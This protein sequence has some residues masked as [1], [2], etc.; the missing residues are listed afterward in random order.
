LLYAVITD[1]VLVH[2]IIDDTA[3][4]QLIDVNDAACQHLGYTREEL[5]GMK[6]TDSMPLNRCGYAVN[7]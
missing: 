5:L 1:A 3:P 6:I 7:Y 4:G 2:D